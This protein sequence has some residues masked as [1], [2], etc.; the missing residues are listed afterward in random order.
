M[1]TIKQFIIASKTSSLT[2]NF[3]S[4][5]QETLNNTMNEN[6]QSHGINFN[7]SFE[8][9][10]VFSPSQT[11]DKKSKSANQ[12][13]SH[14]KLVQLLSIE[15]VAK[16]GYRLIFDDGH[17]AIFSEGYLLE[18]HKHHDKMWEKYLSDLKASGHTREA[19]IDITQL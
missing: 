1:L 16:H 19:T 8:F 11:K 3:V 17:S 13:I 9:L 15:S 10:R 2:V 6:E 5:N 18:L 7:V 4:S 14:K 12:V